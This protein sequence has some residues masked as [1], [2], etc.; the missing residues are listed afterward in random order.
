MTT[1]A[2]TLDF[3]IKDFK[4]GVFNYDVPFIHISDLDF[5]NKQIGIDNVLATAYVNAS[6]DSDFQLSFK[7]ASAGTT[8][9]I[10]YPVNANVKYQDIVDAG[11]FKI[12]TSDY[13]LTNAKIDGKYSLGGISL[14][15]STA[16]DFEI[17]GALGDSTFSYNPA[18]LEKEFTL[19]EITTDLNKVELSTPLTLPPLNI[20]FPKLELA[21]KPFEKELLNGVIKLQASFPGNIEGASDLKSADTLAPVSVEGKSENALFSGQISIS[22]IIE[23]VFL[24]ALTGTNAL[25]F[26]YSTGVNAAGVPVENYD[27]AETGFKLT[28]ADLNVELGAYMTN[29]WLFAPDAVMV[30]MTSSLGEVKTGKLGDNFYFKTPEKGTGDITVTAEYGL[31]GKLLTRVGI[32]GKTL[33]NWEFFVW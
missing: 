27:D 24:P 25:K 4:T 14:N 15:A 33:F 5:Q 26:E 9:N 6:L 32:E 16:F 18:K 13:K 21:V 19:L 31:S 3:S 2:K 10:A 30:K 17:N 20:P 23:N 12:D 8:T 1:Q 22:K 7:L 28:I 11:T 29:D